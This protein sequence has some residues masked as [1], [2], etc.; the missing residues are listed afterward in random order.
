MNLLFFGF[1][2]LAVSALLLGAY[3][4]KDKLGMSGLAATVA[5]LQFLQAVVA[6]TYFWEISGG[7]YVNPSSAILFAGNLAIL[8]YAFARDG[9]VQARTVLYAV[10]IGNLVPGVMGGLLGMHIDLVEPLNRLDV[11]AE[12]FGQGLMFS[13]VGIVVLYI[14]QL[15]A[16]ISFS[17][18]RRK[19]SGAPI[20]LAM[21]IALVLT[22]SFDTVA[23]VT[24]LFW[25]DPEITSL[26][27]SGLISKNL[28]GLA[29]GV[30]W[31]LYLQNR[32]ADQESP[33]RQVLDVM[34]FQENIESLR[35][36]A[37]TDPMTGLLNR[38]AY[39]LMIGEMLDEAS[40]ADGE[41]FAFVLCDVDHF[42]EVNDTLGHTAGDA[43]LAEIAEAIEARVRGQDC[44][45]RIGGDEFLILLPDSTLD[46]AR[47]V[48]RRISSI[49]FTHPKLDDPVTLTIGIAAFPD[50]GL[51]QD[52]LFDAADRRLYEGK[53]HGRNRVVAAQ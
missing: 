20:V 35:E 28:G 53:S 39:D 30:I 15:L 3:R 14:D 5:S 49:R 37:T 33:P 44:A 45:F 36:A 47:D 21:T 50:D 23:Y 1:E 24:V 2:F 26:L 38:R 7:L 41:K 29:Y 43:V 10:V 42:K 19:M 12:I 52:A 13:L 22:L 40:G 6:A 16:V 8:L 4:L 51:T 32:H 48:A 9:A 25:N 34:L 46:E 18:L 27:L 31:G 11:P 17:W